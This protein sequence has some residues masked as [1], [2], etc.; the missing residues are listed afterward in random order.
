MPD[1]RR[2][3]QTC[4]SSLALASSSVVW[5]ALALVWGATVIA[6]ALESRARRRGGLAEV[7]PLLAGGVAVTLALYGLGPL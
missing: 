3:H 1:S 2:M 5:A 6:A 4:R 7:G